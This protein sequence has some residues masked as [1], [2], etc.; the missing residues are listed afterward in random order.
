MSARGLLLADRLL[1]RIECQAG[2]QRAGDAPAHDPARERVDDEGH[3]HQAVPRRN[4][5]IRDSRLVGTLRREVPVHLIP[6]RSSLPS[7]PFCP[8]H[9]RA[10]GALRHLKATGRPRARARPKR[11]GPPRQ[12]VHRWGTPGSPTFIATFGGSEWGTCSIRLATN[13]IPS[14]IAKRPGGTGAVGVPAGRAAVEPSWPFGPPHRHSPT[15]G[16]PCRF[17]PYPCSDGTV[18]L[19]PQDTC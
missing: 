8:P 5:G 2:A 16:F 11:D 7:W 4:A 3:L 10:H 15:A 9:E 12:G 1:E 19:R 6:G 17:H 14:P 18:L 13:P